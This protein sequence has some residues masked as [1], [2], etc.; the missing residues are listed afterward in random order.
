METDI[1]PSSAGGLRGCEATDLD[2]GDETVIEGDAVSDLGMACT[3]LGLTKLGSSSG[4]YAPD[5]DIGMLGLDIDG[6]P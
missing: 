6:V 1:R 4:V 2:I 3:G 5:G